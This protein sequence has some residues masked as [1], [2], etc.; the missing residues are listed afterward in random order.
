MT[1]EDYTPEQ[2]IAAATLEDDIYW[3]DADGHDHIVTVPDGAD[4]RRYGLR[5]PLSGSIT[6][7]DHGHGDAI[8]RGDGD[9]PAIRDDGGHGSAIRDD[10]GR[11]NAIRRGDGHGNAIRW[12]GGRGNALTEEEWRPMTDNTLPA[13]LHRIRSGLATAEDAERVE[14]EVG[15]LRYENAALREVLTAAVECWDGPKY[16]HFMGPVIDMAR[17]PP[18]P[19]TK[20]PYAYLRLRPCLRPATHT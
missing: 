17:A 14:E 11:G 9:G 13:I 3:L 6:V 15:Q 16:R 10:H 12:G 7:Q 4:W 20:P 18:A 2:F 19:R 5:G 1:T 8:R